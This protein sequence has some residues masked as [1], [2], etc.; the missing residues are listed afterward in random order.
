MRITIMY[1][2]SWR[3]AKTILTA[4]T[5]LAIILL[6][7]PLGPVASQTDA[8]ELLV[9][10]SG[11]KALSTI[12]DGNQIVLRVTL[13]NAA[14]AQTDVNFTQRDT[15]TP[16]A[17][18]SILT[19]QRMCDSAPVSTLGWRWNADGSARPQ[20]QIEARASD[21]IFLAGAPITVSPRPVVMAH[22]FN[23]SWET[24]STYLGPQ[25]F[26]APLGIAGF[27]VGDGQM[28]GVMDT[29]S[30]SQ[31]MSRTNTIA[32]N[33]A[34]LG[35]TITAVRQATGAEKVD[36]IVHSMGGMISRYYIDRLMPEKDVAQLIILGTPMAG[37]AC[38]VLP[39]SLGILLPATLEIQPSYM[40]GV[41][42]RQITHRNGVA[43]HALAGTRIVQ[44]VQSPCTDVP[45]DLIVSSAS[46]R[47]LDMPVQEMALLHTDLTTSREVFEDYVAPLLRTAPG[48]FDIAVPPAAAIAPGE[49]LQY[50]RVFTGH[51]T[52]GQINTV[53]IP[54]DAGVS[55]ANFAMYDTSR[56]LT[57]TVT[58]ASGRVIALDARVNGVVQVSDPRSLLFLGY[59]FA[60]PRAGIWRVA[61]AATTATPLEGAD[62]AITAQFR[63][64]AA[65]DAQVAPLIPEIGDTVRVTATLSANG[66]LLAL[67]E[68]SA[69]LRKPDGSSEPI[70]MTV[71]DNIASASIPASASG[72]HGLSIAVRSAADD[73]T[74]VDRAAFLAFEVQPETEAIARVQTLLTTTIIIGGALLALAGG[75]GVAIVAARRRGA[76]QRS[77]RQK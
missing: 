72:A 59:G 33:A 54:I 71:Q 1:H 62:F 31:P 67:T 68:A 10:S 37:T 34:E 53:T 12:V 3:T 49:P 63:G 7:T 40:T 8:P 60:R 46:V 32:Q 48:G 29:G 19:G 24:W 18:C 35:R 26:L 52:P 15:Q 16:I 75:L 25:G 6:P 27:A 38:A 42:N 58:G 57:T 28:P 65:L 5:G 30:M 70:V 14:T 76:S 20:R 36:L 50:T 23:S 66:A 11:G 41:F 22:G 64:G 13:S 56:S 21:G 77:K 47:A 73:G 69:L 74:P 61:V 39:A 17:A 9:L 43:F 4:F 2:M 45:S 51:V 55:M 44:S